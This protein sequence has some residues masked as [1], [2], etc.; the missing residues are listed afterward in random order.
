MWPASDTYTNLAQSQNLTIY[1]HSTPSFLTDPNRVICAR[2]LKLNSYYNNYVQ[3]ATSSDVKYVTVQ[4]FSTS[5][6]PLALQEIRVFRSSTQPAGDWT[7]Q[8]QLSSILL[9]NAM[10]SWFQ[11]AGQSALCCRPPS[12]LQSVYPH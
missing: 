2:K 7:P 10:A 9:L 8:V 11:C 1:L 6:G 12:G 3:C 4:R 5:P